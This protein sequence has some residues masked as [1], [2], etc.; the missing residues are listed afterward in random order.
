[1]QVG[2]RVAWLEWIYNWKADYSHKMLKSSWR[3]M[4]LEE[5]FSEQVSVVKEAHHACCRLIKHLGG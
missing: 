3:G 1:M 4:K 5:T 2:M